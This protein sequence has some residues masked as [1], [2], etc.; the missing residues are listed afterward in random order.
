[1]SFGFVLEWNLLGLFFEGFGK[2]GLGI[3]NVN[4]DFKTG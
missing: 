2:L 1:M 4:G 3:G